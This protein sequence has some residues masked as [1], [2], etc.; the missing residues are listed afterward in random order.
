MNTSC[1]IILCHDENFGVALSNKSSCSKHLK[2]IRVKKAHTAVVQT[3]VIEHL[4]AVHLD[5]KK[6]SARI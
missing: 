4:L 3:V 2:K 5:Q 6:S 1:Q